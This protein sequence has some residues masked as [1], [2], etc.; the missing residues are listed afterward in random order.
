MFEETPKRYLG[1]T[2]DIIL[3]VSFDQSCL[4][5]LY[6]QIQICIQDKIF[7]KVDTDFS[8]NKNNNSVIPAVDRTSEE[9]QIVQRF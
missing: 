6:I 7:Q 5:L 1:E 2:L 3:S 9:I 4:I 8:K